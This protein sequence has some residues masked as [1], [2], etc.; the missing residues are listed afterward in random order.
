[1]W[2]RTA[3]P[4]CEGN[5]R[6]LNRIHVRLFILALAPALLAQGRS[7]SFSLKPDTVTINAHARVA[8]FEF[9][10]RSARPTVF[11]VDIEGGKNFVVVPSVFLVKPYETETFRIALRTFALPAREEKYNVSVVEVVPDSAT[12]PP[13][14]RRYAGTLVLAP[15]S[16]PKP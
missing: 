10:S 15:A 6:L 9:S 1:M 11:E 8:E 2:H 3:L 16:S 12:P 4:N 7:A 14:A 5:T 13:S